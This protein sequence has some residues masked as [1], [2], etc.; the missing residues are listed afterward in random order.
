MCSSDLLYLMPEDVIDFELTL[1]SNDATILRRLSPERRPVISDTAII[2][3]P[4]STGV[5]AFL[6]R[7]VDIEDVSLR[8]VPGREYWTVDSLRSPVIEFFGCHFD[9]KTLKRGRLFYD[10]GYYDAAGAWF[11][12]PRDF[13]S[14]AKDIFRIA[15]KMFKKDPELDAYV[16]PKAREWHSKSHGGLVSVSFAST[17]KP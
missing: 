16:G 14:W 12:K 8:V 2:Q 3:T 9:G 11:D 7:A 17:P 5:D 13:N 6:V 1:R 15:R 10:K 4:E